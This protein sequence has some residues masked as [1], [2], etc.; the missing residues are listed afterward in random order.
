MDEHELKRPTKQF[1]LR[2]MTLVGALSQK[3]VTGKPPR[4]SK[5]YGSVVRELTTQLLP[6]EAGRHRAEN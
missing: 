2:M 3:R 1:A 4:K 6:A 5:Q